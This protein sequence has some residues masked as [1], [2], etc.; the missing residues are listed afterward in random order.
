M[1]RSECANDEEMACTAARPQPRQAEHRECG[2]ASS[3][4]VTGR[5]A[6]ISPQLPDPARLRLWCATPVTARQPTRAIEAH[7]QYRCDHCPRPQWPRVGSKRTQEPG[8][9]LSGCSAT[10]RVTRTR[11]RIRTIQMPVSAQ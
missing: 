7:P 9:L 6:E 11:L 8:A 5:A 10:N 2:L 4:A 1:N 3:R